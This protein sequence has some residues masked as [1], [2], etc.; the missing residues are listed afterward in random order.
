MSI[1]SRKKELPGKKFLLGDEGAVRTRR[2]R[3]KIK[4]LFLG[5]L[6][7]VRRIPGSKATIEDSLP[8]K[9]HSYSIESPGG[10]GS[11]PEFWFADAGRPAPLS[12][13]QIRHDLADLE[14]LADPSAGSSG[15]PFC[16]VTLVDPSAGSSWP[17]PLRGHLSQTPPRGYL[18]R[19][20]RRVILADILAEP[21]RGLILADSSVGSSWPTP[22]RGHLGRPFRG[23]ILVDPSAGSSWPNSVGSSW[24]TPSRGH[25]GRL[26]RGVILANPSAWSSLPTLS[27]GY[28]GRSLCAVI[29]AKPLRGVI[30][31]DSS[32]WSSWPNPSGESSWPT[33]PRGHLSQPFAGSSWLTP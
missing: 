20:L 33:P 5:F 12:K 29:L 23:V 25:L 21:I 26:L 13:D 22:P 27:R 15:R 1:T 11:L 3:S 7:S 2:S 24:P 4:M 30:L 17:N 19:L 31:G 14:V 18:C 16:G 32:V 6:V 28:L 8:F 9:A 10:S